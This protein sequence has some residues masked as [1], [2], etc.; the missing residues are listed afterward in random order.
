M[1]NPP[2]NF[3]ELDS[4][5]PWNVP[6]TKKVKTHFLSDKNVIPTH[7][8]LVRKRTLDNSAKLAHFLKKQKILFLTLK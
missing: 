6:S 5:L 7:N 8:H 2:Q 4:T 3:G 1:S